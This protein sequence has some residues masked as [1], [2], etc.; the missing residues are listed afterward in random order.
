MST[1]T[2][3]FTG[4]VLLRYQDGTID[5]EYQ[6]G[7]PIMTD[8]FESAVILAVFGDRT[9]W[10]NAIVNDDTEKY[11]STFPDIIDRALISD[12]TKDD[13]TEALKTAL[14]FLTESG[15]AAKVEV[16]GSIYSVVGIV[17]TVRIYAPSRES[18]GRY[19]LNW[20]RGSLTFGYERSAA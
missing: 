2:M 15:A 11:V 17:W 13:G 1:N 8:G 10:Q 7:Q 9:T 4:D 12:Q 16:S 6:D 14:R 3:T 18:A 5:I 20:E 19:V